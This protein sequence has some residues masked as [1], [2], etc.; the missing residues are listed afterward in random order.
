MYTRGRGA[1]TIERG[2]GLGYRGIDARELCA[3]RK[4]A[5]LFWRLDCRRVDAVGR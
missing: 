3:G 2:M 5:R 4:L 1:G